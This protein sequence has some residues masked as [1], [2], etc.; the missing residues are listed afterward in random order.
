MSVCKA[1]CY[2]EAK[3][4]RKVNKP[5]LLKQKPASE[6]RSKSRANKHCITITGRGAEKQ[7]RKWG[8]LIKTEDEVHH[9][10]L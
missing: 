9:M 5:E 10:T 2:A 7:K 1:Q 4:G 8:I 3:A 6:G